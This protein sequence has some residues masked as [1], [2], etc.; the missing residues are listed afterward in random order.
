MKSSAIML[1]VI[2]ALQATPGIADDASTELEELTVTARRILTP[3]LGVE[4]LDAD[5]I[6]RRRVRSSDT[7][8]L[9]KGIPGVSVYGAGGVSGLPV[10]R[11][12]AD[13]RLRTQVD[14]ADIA[15]ACPNHMNPPLSYIDPSAV[16]SV[17]VY[18]GVTPVS[19]GGDS[20][21]G[22]ILLRS[23]DPEFAPTGTGSLLKGDA[24]TFYRSYGD[25][26]GGNL[27]GSYATEG[28]SFGYTGA[29][30]TSGNY[31][32][33]NAFKNYTFT[34]RGGHTL[35]TDEVGSTAYETSN[36]AVRIAWRNGSQLLDFSYSYQDVP[37]QLYP[38][39]RMDMTGNTASKF[40]LAYTSGFDWGTLQARAYY[41]ATEHAMDFGPDKRFWYGPGAPPTGSGGD[42][43]V[44]GSPCAP[45]SGSRMVA[46]QMVGC[47]AGMPMLAD[48]STTGLAANTAIQLSERALLRVGGEYVG[49]RLD[50]WWPPSGAGMW[51][52]DFLNINDGERDRYAAYG[53]WEVRRERWQHVAGLRYEHVATDAGPVHGYNTNTFPTGGTGGMGNQTR[54]AALFNAQSR[55]QSDDNW[56]VSWIAGFTPSA[57]QTYEFGLAQ[58][59]RSPN[60]YERYTWSSWQM[61]ALMN[62]FVGDGNG[63][64]GDV[65]LKPEVARTVSA[66]ADWH[67]AVEASWSV[68][69]TPYYTKVD[70]FIDAVQ[71][72]SAANLPRA[73]PVVDN[74][75]VL[76]YANQSATLYG[77]DFRAASRLANSDRFGK[78]TA[79]LIGSYARGENDDT[80]DGLYN[81]MPVNAT[82]SLVQELGR[83]RNTLEGEFVDGK[84]AVAQVRNEMPTAGYGLLHL[85]ARYEAD[86]WNL[87]LG[88]ENLLDRYYEPPLGG[89]YVGQGTTMTLPPAPNQPRWGT[90][91]PGTG[92][93]VYG[94]VNLQF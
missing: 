37:E 79:G 20:I 46:G 47:A 38:N 58:K 8:S 63:Y 45:I 81:I 43:A 40:N 6:A 27:A 10:I 30:A 71:W 70:D 25:S 72:D 51:P 87:E 80:N 9:L 74:F 50:D 89:A 60:L 39:Q 75:T 42:S 53:E 55:D 66:T 17:E 88:V 94:A 44:N 24:G 49:F 23:A 35:P 22:T 85:R 52:Y 3:G 68:R 77:V 18:A 61:A 65:D 59:T 62:N 15:A 86:R 48:G 7:A 32:A 82:L 2:V 31:A 21:G 36:H 1:V 4:L 84:D 14:G 57:T 91:V 5:Q 13:D 83:W 26:W 34:G 11:G 67:D 69:V 76:R 56:D 41:Q 29:W 54:D 19:V 92:R 28:L 12:L 73:V 90:P 64:F 16:A 33:G 93:S 78:F